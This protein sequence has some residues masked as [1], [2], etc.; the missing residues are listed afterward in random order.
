MGDLSKEVDKRIKERVNSFTGK[1]EYSFGDI[2]MEIERD[3]WSGCKA[4]CKRAIVR[5]RP[6]SAGP[7]LTVSHSPSG[8]GLPAWS[9]H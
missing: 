1:S 4:T 5:I 9:S 6:A 2:S 3:A 7:G 8:H